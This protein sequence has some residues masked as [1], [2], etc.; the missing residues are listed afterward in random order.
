[1]V[2]KWTLCIDISCFPNPSQVVQQGTKSCLQ[3]KRYVYGR[4]T[5]NESYYISL[6]EGTK[7]DNKYSE[8]DIV[9]FTNL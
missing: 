1:M 4:A 5:N 9:V 6:I 7:L 2:Y 3:T 8:N